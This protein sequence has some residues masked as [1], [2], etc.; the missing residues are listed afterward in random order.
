MTI[1]QGAAR[2]RATGWARV[3]VLLA[4]VLLVG[5]GAWLAWDGSEPPATTTAFRVTVDSTADLPEPEPQR[6]QSFSTPPLLTSAVLVGFALAVLGAVLVTAVVTW[7]LALRRTPVAE[8]RPG[9]PAPTTVPGS[10]AGDGPPSASGR[11]AAR[12]GHVGAAAVAALGAVLVAAGA[13]LAWSPS[14][15]EAT[16]GIARAGVVDLD[17][18]PP[19]TTYEELPRTTLEAS[20]ARTYAEL[21]RFDDGEPTEPTSHVVP[22]L[23][24]GAIGLALIGGA[25]GWVTER[26]R[27]GRIDA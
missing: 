5:G 14:P 26:R 4:G 6:F 27:S 21:E 18:I 3:L 15:V 10:G 17:E 13:L 8:R 24:V 22:G 11:V 7:T 12:R 2:P 20:P 1:E 19:G 16:T 25:V 9:H 23:A